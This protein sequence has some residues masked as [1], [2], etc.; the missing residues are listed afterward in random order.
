V[1]WT[2]YLLFL[3]WDAWW[4]L[5]FVLPSF[6]FIMLGVGAVAARLIAWR[7]AVLTPAV[8]VIV[9]FVGLFQIHVAADRG[10]FSLWTGDRRYITAA[11][12]TRRMTDS[13]SLI[14]T[15]VHVG[16]VRYYGSRMSAYVGYFPADWLDRGIAW[17]AGRGVRSYLLLEDWEIPEFKARFEGQQTVRILD[18]PPVAI[19]QDPGRMYLFDLLQTDPSLEPPRI[20]TGVDEGVWAT[21]PA[22]APRF[23]FEH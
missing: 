5:R 15:G 7:P 3:P 4:Y 6:P 18:L 14:F 10:V 1:I 19:Y 9:L 2:T 8:A 17:L 22:P 21:P 11:Q 12:M 13:H 23:G 16:S 20:W